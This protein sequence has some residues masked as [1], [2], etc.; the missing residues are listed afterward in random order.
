M[1]SCLRL[2]S[3][4]YKFISVAHAKVMAQGTAA[5]IS[6]AIFVFTD[7]DSSGK[8]RAAASSGACWEIR[9]KEG[10]EEKYLHQ[11][12]CESRSCTALA[13]GQLGCPWIGSR[14]ASPPPPKLSQTAI[15][16]HAIHTA[17]E[18]KENCF[19]DWGVFHLILLPGC[20]LKH[21]RIL[22]RLLKMS[23]TTSMRIICIFYPPNRT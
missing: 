12:L 19:K 4:H 7:R 13:L 23:Q 22:K 5:G 20:P 11:N 3:K 17:T 15:R 18:S 9:G 10:D 8:S 14:F 21:V 1:P 16:T 2:S 6:T